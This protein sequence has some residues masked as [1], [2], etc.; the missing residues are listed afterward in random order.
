MTALV[1]D[2]AAIARRVLSELAPRIAALERGGVR[3]G[4][5][6]IVVGN[7]VASRAYVRNKARA[8]A[9]VGVHAEVHELDA[10]CG[11]TALMG[12]VE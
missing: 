2:G 5:A 9:E 10:D 1:L 12:K 6:T 3:P 4:L 7:N 8:C 11:E